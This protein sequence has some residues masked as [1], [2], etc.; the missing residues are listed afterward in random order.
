MSM[1][2]RLA[3]VTVTG[4]AA[5]G[6]TLTADTSA[7]ADA[8]G[9]GTF[10]YQWKAGGVDIDGA[11][12]S[13]YT[14]TQAEVGKIV[15]ASV[16]YTDGEGT[17]ETVTSAAIPVVNENPAFDIELLSTS[18]GVATFE[19]YATAV[20]DVGDPGLG[21]FQFV[22]SHDV[23]DMTIDADSF[24]SASGLLA[25]RPNPDQSAGTLDFAGIF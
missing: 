17:L 19:V 22:L 3:S 15:T 1:M 6:G 18:G 9:L 12:S 25:A 14:L 13:T 23:A 10:S 8:D 21:S 16:S 20:A 24:V 4:T 5:Q 11:T 2:P 7:L